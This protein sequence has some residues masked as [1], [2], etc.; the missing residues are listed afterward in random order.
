MFLKHI[1][2]VLYKLQLYSTRAY[3][4]EALQLTE[5]LPVHFRNTYRG[6]LRSV[7]QNVEEGLSMLTVSDC[8]HPR[9]E[10]VKPQMGFQSDVCSCLLS[11][12][13]RSN[14]LVGWNQCLAFSLIYFYKARMERI[15]NFK[16]SEVFLLYTEYAICVYLKNT[17][18]FLR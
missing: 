12:T 2:Y 16:T 8:K 4:N 9:L 10:A 17:T 3:L 1:N 18:V 6:L 13:S 15:N 7:R 5:W 11:P 14:Y